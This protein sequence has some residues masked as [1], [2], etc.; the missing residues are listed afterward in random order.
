[1]ITDKLIFKE[2]GQYD[3]EV[4]QRLYL[5]NQGIS[6]I[7][8]L[9]SCVSL[10]ELVLSSNEI[11]MIAGL[12]FCVSL[13]TLDLSFNRIRKIEN[14]HKLVSLESLD[15]RGNQIANLADISD[16]NNLKTLTSFSLRGVDGEDANPVCSQPG[17][18]AA[19]LTAVPSLLLMD[20]GH[21]QIHEAFGSIEDELAKLRP[22]PSICKTP[23]SEPW[24]T[25]AEL[26]VSDPLDTGATTTGPSSKSL[27]AVQEQEKTIQNMLSEDCSH[28]L[29]KAQ[30]ALAKTS[31]TR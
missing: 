9:E 21:V 20:G 23:P 10:V 5:S 13:R 22:D 12:D 7:S 8:N 26:A 14:L 24:F 3:K 1:M 25:A 27:K 18:A 16:L 19:V 11:L 4:I 28:L 15:L 6:S 30:A 2:S 17:Y 29:R 31:G